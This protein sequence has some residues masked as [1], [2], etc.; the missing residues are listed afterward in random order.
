MHV[1]NGAQN[2]KLFLW[3]APLFIFRI[4][5]NEKKMIK[6]KIDITLSTDTG[7]SSNIYLLR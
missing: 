6:T 3:P 2:N 1:E 5:K 4:P 7:N